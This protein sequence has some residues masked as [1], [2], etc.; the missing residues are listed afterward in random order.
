MSW[1]PRPC[2]CS[3]AK[4][5]PIL[6]HPMDCSMPGLSLLRFMLTESVILSNHLILCLLLLLLP[7]IFP[8]NRVFS[9]K[10][11]ACQCTRRRRCRFDPWVGKIPW[12]RAW[13]P[14]PVFLSGESHGHKSLAG[15]R[16][17]GCKEQDTTERTCIVALRCCITF[18]YITNIC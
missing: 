13:Q 18:C 16:P 17:W 8:N 15:Y 4:S 5:C 14:T 3:V 6:C 12:R 1:L 7:S 9:S 10:E 2:H 11:F